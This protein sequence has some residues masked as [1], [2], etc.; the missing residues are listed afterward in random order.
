[1]LNKEVAEA[2]QAV[3][4]TDD[5]PGPKI[6]LLGMPGGG[7]TAAIASA[8]NAGLEVFVIFTEQG[9]ESL[10]EGLDIH[11]CQDLRKNLHWARVSPGSPGFKAMKQLAREINRKEQKELQSS[12]GVLEKDYTQMID[13]IGLCENF[14]DQNG[15]EYG[16]VTTWSNKRIL[17]LDGL[18]GVNVM[19]M[20]LVV[21]GKPVKTIADWGI[22]MD[23]QMRFFMQC[24]NSMTAA[25][26][27]LGHLEINKDEVD[28]KMYKFPKLLGNKNSYDFGKH[29]S[30][31]ILAEDQGNKFTWAT[32]ASNMQLK[33]RNLKRGINLEPD[34]VPLF[35]KWSSRYVEKVGGVWT[36]R[37]REGTESEQQD[38]T[39]E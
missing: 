3:P 20:D 23:A 9:Q 37:D 1:M 11:K 27:L 22:A 39:A 12:K 14:V 17:F 34:F 36:V 7:K 25:F 28:G 38:S 6:L 33:S 15:V 29:F 32:Q 5:Y 16:D 21:G 31:V 8:L 19:A 26:C 4:N 13:L 30:D 35:D 10:L 2:V 24:V 18:S